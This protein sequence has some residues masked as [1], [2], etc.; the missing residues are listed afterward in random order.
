MTRDGDR[1]SELK[2]YLGQ[3]RPCSAHKRYTHSPASHNSCVLP[4]PSSLRA[5]SEAVSV[6]YGREHQWVEE[7]SETTSI[8]GKGGVEPVDHETKKSL[9]YT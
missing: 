8:A 7:S 2:T 9:I 1:A 5:L 3:S 4:S 6:D